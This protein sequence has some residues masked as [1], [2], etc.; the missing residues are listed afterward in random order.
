[1]VDA[2][3]HAAPSSAALKIRRAKPSDFDAIRQNHARTFHEHRE[4][5]PDF[6]ADAPFI[7]DYLSEIAQPFDWIRG[8]FK[9]ERPFGLVA[10]I[11]GSTIGH[12]VYMRYSNSLG[13]YAAVIA[14]ISIDPS[15]R[16][17]GIGRKLIQD[18]ERREARDG[19]TSFAATVWPYNT[20]SQDMFSALGYTPFESREGQDDP[21][22][23]LNKTIEFGTLP[24]AV[25]LVK[26]A[27][28]TFLVIAVLYRLAMVTFT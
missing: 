10:E 5:E 4:R 15:H 2:S 26:S 17:A 23:L 28:L 19:V 12:I 3:I 24:M 9:K 1:M 6:D 21:Q 18:M 22:Q 8:A 20:A 25:I 11:D 14:D 13:P 27:V 16:G 7:D